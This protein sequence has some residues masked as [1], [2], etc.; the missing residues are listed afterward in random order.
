VIAL[1]ARIYERSLLRIGPRVRLRE[2]LR[3]S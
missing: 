2:V 3:E 1:G